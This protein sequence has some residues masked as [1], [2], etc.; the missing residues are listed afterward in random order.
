MPSKR[1]ALEEEAELRRRDS[2]AA[3]QAEAA[4]KKREAEEAA[5]AEV[6][7]GLEEEAR[8]AKA[9]TERLA[10]EAASALDFMN[11]VTPAAPARAKVTRKIQVVNPKGFIELYNLWFM[12]EGINLSMTD[13]EKVHKKMITFCEKEANRDGGETV[14]SAFIRYVDDVKAK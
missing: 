8:R 7:R 2:E 1:K 4:R 14:K 10:A 12:R 5:C 13:L 9:E 6:E 3:A 11:E